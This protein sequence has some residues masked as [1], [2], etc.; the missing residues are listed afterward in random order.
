MLVR[1]WTTPSGLAIIPKPIH[2]EENVFI[3]CTEN[4]TAT[5][6]DFMKWCV[7]PKAG[8]GGRA[9]KKGSSL[10]SDRGSATGKQSVEANKSE[11]AGR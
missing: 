2:Y 8:R 4:Q 1:K 11:T 10:N 6:R 3:T 5:F 9:G 7:D